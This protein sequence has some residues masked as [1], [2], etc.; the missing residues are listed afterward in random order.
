VS[1]C[2]ASAGARG[3]RSSEAGA[4]QRVRLVWSPPGGHRRDPVGDDAER[5]AGPCE[6]AGSEAQNDAH[7]RHPRSRWSVAILH[8][9]TGRTEPVCLEGYI[10]VCDE[11]AYKG[12]ETPVRKWASRSS[13]GWSP[14]TRSRSSA[15]QRVS[16]EHRR[17]G[18]TVRRLRLSRS[19]SRRGTLT[20]AP[21]CQCPRHRKT[22]LF[23][24]PPRAT[25]TR[26]L[27]ATSKR[28]PAGRPAPQLFPGQIAWTR[29][30]PVKAA[31]S[32]ATTLM[33]TYATA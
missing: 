20:R 30:A 16:R 29:P 25:L 32:D 19:A 15:T 6:E 31:P 24:A 21:P 7:H 10:P 22:C 33:T 11:R 8:P 4:G 12:R 9:D 17:G 23:A 18:G 14:S 2:P 27:A 3:R 26:Y 5:G 13:K 1:E 28:A